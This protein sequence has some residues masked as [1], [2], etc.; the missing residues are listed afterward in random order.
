MMLLPV[1]LTAVV[2]TVPDANLS[3]AVE[4]IE[5]SWVLVEVQEDG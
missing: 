1:L 3:V 5:G 2:A 4:K